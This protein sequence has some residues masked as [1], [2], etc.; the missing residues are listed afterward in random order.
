MRL[1]KLRARL[2]F[3]IRRAWQT[4]WGFALVA[5]MGALLWLGWFPGLAP[6]RG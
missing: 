3:E 5:T 6:A 4:V 1:S 2:A